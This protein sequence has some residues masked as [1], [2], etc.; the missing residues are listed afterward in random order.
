MDISG[1]KIL[2]FNIN[3]IW[4]FAFGLIVFASTNPDG[5]LAQKEKNPFIVIRKMTP[6][7]MN[8]TQLEFF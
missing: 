8:T 4:K 3:S 5:E 7:A 1:K 6:T 2:G